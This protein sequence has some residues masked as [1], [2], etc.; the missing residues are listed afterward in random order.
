LAFIDRGK[1]NLATT[2]RGEIN[3]SID[4]PKGATSVSFSPNSKLAFLFADER[5]FVYR[6]RGGKEIFSFAIASRATSETK[7]IFSADKK[8]MTP[9]NPKSKGNFRIYATPF[10]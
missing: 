8:F 10:F 7:M 4:L 5:V 6:L 3:L 9:F 1:L 2:S